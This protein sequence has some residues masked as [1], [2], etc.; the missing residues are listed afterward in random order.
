[1]I[2]LGQ[3][4]KVTPRKIWLYSRDVRVRVLESKFGTNPGKGD[5]FEVLVKAK[6]G[7]APKPGQRGKK[8]IHT[9]ILRQYGP[10]IASLSK[11]GILTTRKTWCHCDCSYFL[12]HCEVAL[13]RFESSSIINS[14]GQPPIHTNPRKIPRICKH[15]IALI[16]IQP[17]L[18]LPVNPKSTKSAEGMNPEIG[19]DSRKTT[20]IEQRLLDLLGESD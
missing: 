16:S 5:Y 7:S 13:T 11:G 1:M 12:F 20:K 17:Q 10:T 18:R 4:L 9:V 2:S 6:T 14:N 15:I 3:M 8:E 19:A